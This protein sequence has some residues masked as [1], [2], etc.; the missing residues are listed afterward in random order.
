[1]GAQIHCKKLL[2]HAEKTATATK[3]KFAIV[4]LG[5]LAVIGGSYSI[6]TENNEAPV[7][8]DKPAETVKSPEN[9]SENADDDDD[10]DDDADGDEGEDDEDEEDE[11]EDED[12]DDDDDDGDDDEDDEEE[13]EEN[14]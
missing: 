1:M 12:E 2:F 3:M 13:T 14:A 11:D 4:L 6:P 9:E 5:L 8:A 10:D 7:I